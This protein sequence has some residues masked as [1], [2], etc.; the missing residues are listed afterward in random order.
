MPAPATSA[1]CRGFNIRAARLLENNVDPWKGSNVPYKLGKFEGWM[2]SWTMSFIPKSKSPEDIVLIISVT[3]AKMCSTKKCLK[4]LERQPQGPCSVAEPPCPWA[5]STGTDHTRFVTINWRQ[6]H[7]SQERV[8]A[9]KGHTRKPLQGQTNA[10]KVLKTPVSLVL[11]Q[12][13]K[14]KDTPPILTVK[15]SATMQFRAARSLWTNLLALRY[16]MPSAISPAI[17]IILL[18]LGGARTGLFCWRIKKIHMRILDFFSMPIFFRGLQIIFVQ[19]GHRGLFM[20]RNQDLLGR[21]KPSW[22]AWHLFAPASLS[23]LA[24]WPHHR[25][26]EGNTSLLSLG[27]AFSIV[28]RAKKFFKVKQAIFGS[29]DSQL[30]KLLFVYMFLLFPSPKYR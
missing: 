7:H 18:R 30:L 5:I 29:K 15:S 25:A 19:S 27:P 2:Q 12:I 16:A 9:L 3:N 1:P 26:A 11:A 13:W 20:L 6:S 17:W 4:Y 14:A 23:A 22:R 21:N 24:P 28:G 8:H 10:K